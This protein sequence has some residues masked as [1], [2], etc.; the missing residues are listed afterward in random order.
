MKILIMSDSH[1]NASNMQDAAEAELPNL[2]LH[3]GDCDSDCSVFADSFP[4][5]SVRSV[6]GN[7]DPWSNGPDMLDFFVEGKRFFVTHGHLYGVKTG[8][9]KIM[10]AARMRRADILLFGHTHKPRYEAKNGLILLNPGSVG[11]SSRTYAFLEIKDGAVF[12]FGIKA[13]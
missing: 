11:M 13:V 9:Q 10:D 2:I 1:G 7:C 4:D 8:L 3:L 6:R 12:G 5:I